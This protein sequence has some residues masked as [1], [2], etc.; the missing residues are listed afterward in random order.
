[1]TATITSADIANGT[2]A[3]GDISA[4]AQDALSAGFSGPNW[5]VMDRNVIGNGDSYL[6]GWAGFVHVGDRRSDRRVTPAPLGVGSLGIRTGVAATDKA[7]FGNAGRLHWRSVSRTSPRSRSRCSRP[8]RTSPSARQ[9]AA[10][11]DRDR[12]PNLTPG[13]GDYTDDGV[14]ARA[15]A[16]IPWMARV[17]R[18]ADLAQ[19]GLTGAEGDDDR[20]HIKSTMCTFE[21]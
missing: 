14:R 17:R 8:A 18:G 1:M 3:I 19:L 16:A 4:A 15:N 11:R 21:T 20:V 7:A 5:G 6:R 12:S 13:V 2:I 10:H 9:P